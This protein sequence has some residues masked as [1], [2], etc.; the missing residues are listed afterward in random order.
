MKELLDDLLAFKQNF[1]SS[2]AGEIGQRVELFEQ[3]LQKLEAEVRSHISVQHQLKLH[4]DNTQ[5][6][7]EAAQAA[8]KKQ[9]QSSD[10]LRDQ[11]YE[12]VRHKVQAEFSAEL[13]QQKRRA[14]QAEDSLVTLKNQLQEKDRSIDR[15]RQNYE[16]LQRVRTDKVSLTTQGYGMLKDNTRTMRAHTDYKLFEAK[17]PVKITRSKLR[18]VSKLS[19]PSPSQR[20]FE[21]L[22]P[23]AKGYRSNSKQHMRSFSDNRS[24]VWKRPPSR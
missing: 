2:E 15:L 9:K 4:L 10:G 8:C 21:D 5:S 16:A 23:V 18:Q 7:L 19:R 3:M 12:E 11:L 1:R 6:E 22:K 14:D 20:G 13:A 24:F 17:S